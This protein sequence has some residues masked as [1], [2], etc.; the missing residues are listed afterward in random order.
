MFDFDILAPVKAKLIPWIWLALAA[1]LVSAFV[2][3]GEWRAGSVRETLTQAHQLAI[4]R[5]K[6]DAAATLVHETTEVMRLERALAH[7]SDKLEEKAH[8][9]RTI[10]AGYEKRL[11]AAAA[12]NGGRLRD[13][14]AAGCGRD[15]GGTPTEAAGA[16]GGGAPDAAG[17][18]GLIS[19]QLSDLL[20]DRLRRA[21][22]I[23]IAYAACRA[24]LLSDRLLFDTH[25]ESLQ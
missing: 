3:Y 15:S 24:R 20:R 5:Q 11:A 7:M 19:V 8:E 23:N 1:A 16:A 12:G 22:A 14:N 18:G 17:A 21:D 25:T 10:A 9:Q 2:A 13:P 6:A 4:A